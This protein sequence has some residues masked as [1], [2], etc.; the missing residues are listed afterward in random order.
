MKR[1]T[2]LL[3][4]LLA[5]LWCQ[6]GEARLLR[7]P[8]SVGDKLVFSYA[9]DLYL[10][11]ADGGTARRLT[12]H[13]GYEMFPRISPDGKYIA[14]TGQYDGNTEVFVIPAEGGEPRRL[15]YTATLKRDDLGDRMGPNN[16]V[17]GWTPDSKR[18]LYRSRRYTFNDFTGQLFTV[19][20]EGGMSEEIPL[21]NGGFASYSPNGKKLAYNYIFREFRAWKR[22]QGGMADDIR[23]FDFDT[24]KSE[25]ITNNERQDVFPMWS[26]DGNTIYYISDRNDVMNLFAYNVNT[27]EDK[28]L[29]SYK[30]YDIKFPAI[31]DRRI[32]YEQGGYIYAY[33]LQNGKESKITIH[34][35]NDQ[36]YSRPVLTDVSGQISSVAPS[37]GGERV[38]VAAHGDI[39]SLPVN[40]GITYNLTNSSDANDM[41]AGWSPDGK[42]ISYVSD[43][44]GEFNIYLRD[45]QTGKERKLIKNLKSYIFNYKWSP[46][47]KKILWSEKGNTL[48]ISDVESG[49]RKVIEKSGVSPLTSYN[50]SPDSKYITY[51]RPEAAMNNII[52]YNTESGEKHQ[53]TDGWFGA[54]SPNFS[55]DGKYLVFVS[56]RSFTPTYSQ[57]EWNHAYT[58][59]NKVYILPLAQ[60][61]PIPFAPKNDIVRKETVVEKKDNKK[62][63]SEDKGIVYD[64]SNVE[65]RLIELPVLASNYYGNVH[66]LGNRVYYNRGG[67]T[68]MYDLDGKRETDTGGNIEFAPGYKKAVAFSG[69]A[70]Q[71]V[72]LPVIS[73][74]VGSPVATKGVKKVIDYHQEWMQ[75]YNESWRQMR[76]FFYAKNMHGVDWDHVYEKYKVL[77]PYVNHRTDLTYI[78]GEM[79]GELSVGHAYSIN[80]RVPMPERINMGLLGAK[81]V[82]DKS[83]YFKVT[84]IIEGAN[85]DAS[86]RS[87][88]TMP[89]VD[90]KEGDYILAINGKSLEKV[91]NLFAEL[92]DMAGK[93]VELTV[94]TTPTEKGARE[95]LVVPLADESKLYYYNWV[96]NNI[97]KVSE[98]TNGEVGYI[99]IPDMGVDG[100]NEFVKHYYPQLQK[101]ALIIDDRGN[102]GGNV[103]PMITERLMRTPTFYTMHTNQTA[104]SV[105][106]VGTSLGPKVLLVNEYS[107][108][109]GDLFPYRFKY[110]KLG[111]IIGRR[112]WGG[113]VGYSGSI[114]VV[115][116]GSIVTPSYAPFAA[117]GSDFIIE[118]TGVYPHIDIEN[119]PYLEYNGEDQQLNRAIQEILE[120]L[121]TERKEIPAIPAFP[122]KSGKASKIR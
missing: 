110:N 28:Q 22:Y 67:R 62:K 50:W 58:D 14:F 51:V 97:R 102:G 33:D 121:K 80:G 48:N 41:Q 2:I 13:V 26:P 76:D 12:S 88:L 112:T 101:K 103:S 29:T 70:F 77:V 64:F 94:N 44:D 40:A 3:G 43:K 8:H 53:V 74:S 7:F 71:V 31:G 16:V 63:E 73:A 10:V 20:V 61:A 57:T 34:I 111:T 47:S 95:V 87:P 89:G 98:A 6:A 78:I 90:V 23:V 60:G 122:D 27:K 108:S 54:A 42:Y 117:D 21:T 83:G 37:P 119:D 36:T 72:D 38:V 46:D 69:S 52:V 93:T 96:Q 106:P 109:D 107:A 118:G 32:V 113:V 115:D 56:A 5:G 82:K 35:D 18:I 55:E 66:M 86:T 4:L 84:K 24:K 59:M 25:R 45:V 15:T 99:H 92:I 39:F 116:G 1:F 11:S 68:L 114:R 81:F 17:I 30:E 19:P 100:L 79:I 65:N 9:G 49:N 105:S 120:K 91:D 75:I 85:W 104:G